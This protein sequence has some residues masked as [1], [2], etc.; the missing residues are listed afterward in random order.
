MSRD[1]LVHRL[2][3]VLALLACWALLSRVVDVGLRP[4]PL[5]PQAPP[6]PAEVEERDAEVALT[7]TNA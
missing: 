7:V 3:A 2:I 6:P 5:S 1:R 4:S